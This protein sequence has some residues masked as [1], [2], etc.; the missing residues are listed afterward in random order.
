MANI[1]VLILIKG[2]YISS[3]VVYDPLYIYQNIFAFISFPY[4]L[5]TFII[6][7]FKLPT[8]LKT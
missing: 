5:E 3:I 7:Y 2:W 1:T 4:T 6:L 8:W